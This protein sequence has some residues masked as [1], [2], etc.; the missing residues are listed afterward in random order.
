MTVS[1]D[2]TLF[3]NE[4]F[5]KHGH[6]GEVDALLYAYDQPQRLKAINK[7]LFRVSV[8]LGRGT[9]ILDIGC[10]TGDL[11]EHLLRRD[12]MEITGIDA[13]DQTIAYAEKRFLGREGV[14]LLTMKLEDLDFPSG[15]FDLIFC[16]NVLQH[17][18]D[19]RAFSTA[20][21]QI[22]R[23]LRNS[24]YVLVMDFSPL[25]V[26]NRTPAP[27]LTIRPRYEY[28]EVFE[29]EGCRLV[30]EFGLPRIGVR[31]YRATNR[32]LITTYR[33]VVPIAKSRQDDASTLR[34]TQ[35]S[36]EGKQTIL[37]RMLHTIGWAVLA[38]SKPLDC[39]LAPCP[40]AFTDMRILT[41][42]KIS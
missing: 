7:V 37:L 14:K 4:R 34:L 13:S 22:V 35:S 21:S 12:G 3:W 27:Y 41:F 19:A 42:K 15:S 9:R 2:P 40:S 18:A 33:T 38:L 36:V 20:V 30:H 24:G 6:T 23:V 10:G 32:A 17:I 26:K 8:P 39:L 25:R 16:I 11:I 5:R 29:R 31:V 28:L 1:Y